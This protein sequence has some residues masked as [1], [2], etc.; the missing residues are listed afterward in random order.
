MARGVLVAAPDLRRPTHMRHTALLGLIMLAP[1]LAQAAPAGNCAPTK[2][3]IVLD[4]S[5]SILGQVDASKKPRWQLANEAITQIANTYDKKIALGLNVFPQAS[6]CAPGTTVVKAQLDHGT[7]IIKNLP[8]AP[9]EDGNYTPM[10][11]TIDAAVDDL[12]GCAVKDR[13]ALV[14]ITDGFQW[15]APYDPNTRLL[16][17]DAVK[18]A[19]MKGVPVYVVGFG[20]EVDAFAL[21]QM[22]KEAGTALA[23]CNPNGQT[24][25]AK[26]KCYYQADSAGALITALDSVALKVSAEVC[27]GLD[28]DCN[29]LV[30]DGLV[31]N[32]ANGCGAGT[33]TCQAGTWAG[34]TAPAVSAEVCDGRDN[35]CD[36]TTDEGCVCK[37]GE[38][39]PCGSTMGAC[40]MSQGSQRC[41][42]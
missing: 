3:M 39:R 25:D 13:Q 12:C 38:T 2:L 17:V 9:P 8:G 41:G 18:R 10:A 20:S 19:K 21:N 33:E 42:A 1:A 35:N 4:H 36:G 11:Q 14:V 40:A 31:R 32:C 29:G 5:S 34:C 24:V 22:A 16:G 30:D 23:G 15:C 27:D 28:N 26:N 7:K 6:A 37:A